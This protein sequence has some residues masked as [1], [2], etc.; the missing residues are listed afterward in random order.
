MG[1]NWESFDIFTAMYPN[2]IRHIKRYVS[3][4]DDETSLLLQQIKPLTPKKK[5]FLLQE[6]QVCRYNYFVEQGCLRMFFVNDKGTEQIVQFAL[7]NWWIA[8]YMSFGMQRPSNFSIQAVETSQIVGLAYSQQDELFKQLPQLER[9]FRIM[10]Q[11][12]Y[13]AAQM[14][15][16]FFHDFT[17][18]ESYLHF[19]R[20]FPDFAQRIP[21]YMLASYL[22]ITPEYLSELRKK[23]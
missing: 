9:Y 7:E 8:D 10:M 13:A 19:I 17:K 12:A 6:G 21:Q 22:G 16:K 4:T 20:M 2:F 18:E 11:R 14:R 23:Q 3:L 5:E 1:S 15:V